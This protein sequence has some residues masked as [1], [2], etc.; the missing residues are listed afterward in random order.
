[1]NSQDVI[2]AALFGVEVQPMIYRVAYTIDDARHVIDAD[3]KEDDDGRVTGQV[4]V[5]RRVATADELGTPLTLDEM[6]RAVEWVLDSFDDDAA[7]AGA[8]DIEIKVVTKNT[9]R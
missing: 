5:D 9:I 7:L 4:F 3:I 8:L 1:V 2:E 6:R